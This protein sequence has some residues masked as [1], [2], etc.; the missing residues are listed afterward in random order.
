M[1]SR[2]VFVQQA[3]TDLLL[4][5]FRS[6]QAFVFD[7]TLNDVRRKYQGCDIRFYGYY[8]AF[9]E[10]GK[11]RP[12]DVSEFRYA[13]ELSPFLILH[14]APCPD[15]TLASF[16]IDCNATAGVSGFELLINYDNDN[17][18]NESLELLWFDGGNDG[19]AEFKSIG[20]WR[21]DRD[22][23]L[24]ILT[25]RSHQGLPAPFKLPSIR[26]FFSDEEEQAEREETIQ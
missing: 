13:V 9:P 21:S 6:G 16:M 23:E 1:M 15:K 26:G 17:R 24:G 12:F 20:K 14:H 3:F 22:R 25:W 18:E 10:D 2:D 8:D 7:Y 5:F 4:Y 19:N 11:P